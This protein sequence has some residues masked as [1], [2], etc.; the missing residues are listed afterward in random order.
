MHTDP[1]AC[2]A[3]SDLLTSASSRAIAPPAASATMQRPRTSPSGAFCFTRVAGRC[4]YAF[5]AA[6]RL[7]TSAMTSSETFFGTGS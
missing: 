5:A 4:A 6:L 1:G 2:K 3:Q 7:A